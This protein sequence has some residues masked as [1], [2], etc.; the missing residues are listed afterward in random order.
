MNGPTAGGHLTC[1]LLAKATSQ[2]NVEARLRYGMAHYEECLQ[3]L[4]Y[5]SHNGGFRSISEEKNDKCIAWI[6]TS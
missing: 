3:L 1:F 4:A 5:A 6:M 2:T